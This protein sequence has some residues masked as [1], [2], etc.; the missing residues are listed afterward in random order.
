MGSATLGTDGSIVI[1][2]PAWGVEYRGTVTIRRTGKQTQIL[3]VQKGGPDD[4]RTWRLPCWS[5][6]TD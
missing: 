2:V 1:T 6:Y 3:V 4:G 5:F